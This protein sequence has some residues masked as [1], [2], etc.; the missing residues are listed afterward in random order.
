[1]GSQCRNY[2]S[3]SIN[4][5][6]SSVAAGAFPPFRLGRIEGPR[7]SPFFSCDPVQ[8]MEPAGETG[9]HRRP[10][11]A[12]ETPIASSGPP[13]PLP[14]KLEIR[15]PAPRIFEYRRRNAG[16]ES[17]SN[18]PSS[19]RPPCPRAPTTKRIFRCR[20]LQKKFKTKKPCVRN[21]RPIPFAKTSGRRPEFLPWA[22]SGSVGPG[23]CKSSDFRR[24]ILLT[25][26]PSAAIPRPRHT[27]HTFS[28]SNPLNSQIP[29]PKMW[30]R[31]RHVDWITPSRGRPSVKKNDLERAGFFH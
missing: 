11:A 10:N 9:S 16:P 26:P 19:P 22:K 13:R 3:V 18:H 17:E 1:L 20:S 25:A 8:H 5:L 7:I 23:S 28:R 21:E 30:R 2:P 12:V 29:R 15:D 14:R 6:G 27:Q 4:F 31:V 24:M